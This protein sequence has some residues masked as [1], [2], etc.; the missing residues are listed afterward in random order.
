METS[1]RY[2]GWT[3]AQLMAR[4]QEL[5]SGTR[6]TD[7]AASESGSNILDGQVKEQSSEGAHE[8]IEPVASSSKLAPA[9][10]DRP[11]KDGAEAINGDGKKP[12]KKKE[13]RIFDVSELPMR[14]IALR[15]AYD[16]ENYSGLASQGDGIPDSA[17]AAQAT[18]TL[19]T[20]EGVIWN[21]LCL[22]RLVDPA[23]GMSGAGWS[24]CGRTDK[25]VSAAG[26]VVS[27]WVR[28]SKVDE[29]ELRRR[30]DERL[31]EAD[32]IGDMRWVRADDSPA[33]QGDDELV[34]SKGATTGST[35][36][37]SWTYT[38]GNLLQPNVRQDDRE[39]AYLA[40]LNRLLPSTIR[41]L[42]WAPVRPSFNARFDCRYRHYKYFFTAGPPEQ[43]LP[44][45][46]HQSRNFAAS[47]MNIEA[48]RE[49]AGF[50]LGEH[51]F[52]NLCKVDPSKQIKNFRRRIDGVSIDKVESHWP[53]ADPRAL[54]QRVVKEN[55]EVKA[56]DD[57]DMYV[58]NLRGTAF[59]YH[60]VRHIMAVLLL[61][62]AGMEK[63]TIVKELL[64]VKS[65]AYQEDVK[66]LADAGVVRIG[67]AVL[68]G[69]TATEVDGA[70]AVTAAPELQ[71]SHKVLETPNALAADLQKLT[72]YD[73]KPEY[74]LSADRPLVLWECGFRPSDIQWRTGTYDGP[75]TPEALQSPAVQDD[76]IKAATVVSNDMYRSYVKAAI[77]AEMHRHLFLAAAPA[78]TGYTSSGTLYQDARWPYLAVAKESLDNATSPRPPLNLPFGNGNYRPVASW[79][80]LA[81][82]KREDP[83][84]VK[85]E[86][87]LQG[88][89]RRRADKKGT[90]AERLPT[91]GRDPRP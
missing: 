71:G 65:G 86:R 79:N 28:S 42:G 52:R 2:Q 43:L 44:P 48:M 7:S 49:A 23:K 78:S 66:Y 53:A 26:Q 3:T 46:G 58:L 89:G 69:S 47:R 62:G 74:E 1:Q 12:K 15:F 35:D 61:V 67:E 8:P 41:I 36:V 90:T 27:L 21:A 38:G 81:A 14:K 39:L 40:S 73:R 68:P 59:L 77:S 24:R 55:G 88:K 4:I 51:D 60:Q 11:P 10:S 57:E 72:V 17:T 37:Q 5:E 84:E 22:A 32:R 75:L 18:N 83:V 91:G 25:G 87:W 54:Q 80:G 20:V 85:N 70:T 63:P 56:D 13:K 6:T 29:R 50:L 45:S 9:M 33:E 19:P 31:A 64:N 16:G 34:A 76:L 30:E 82:R